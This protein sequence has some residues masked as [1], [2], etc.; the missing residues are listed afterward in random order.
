MDDDDDDRAL[1]YKFAKVLLLSSLVL[2]TVMVDTLAVE[3]DFLLAVEV[4]S[5]FTS[6]SSP[7]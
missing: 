5:C 4:V 7:A 3:E 2:V 6:I 1:R